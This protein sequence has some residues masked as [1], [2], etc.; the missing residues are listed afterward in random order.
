LRGFSEVLKDVAF[1]I[2]NR[3]IRF[4]GERHYSTFRRT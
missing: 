3:D 4:H 2:R 1:G